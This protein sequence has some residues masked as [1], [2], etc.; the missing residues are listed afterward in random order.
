MRGTGLA[1]A[2]LLSV[3]VA[4]CVAVPPPVPMYAVP[5]QA[6]MAA[7]AAAGAPSPLIASP[8]PGKTE[9]V[10]EADDR[11]CR[12]DV[13]RLPKRAAAAQPTEAQLQAAQAEQA[14]PN[15]LPPPPQALPPGAA[16]LRCMTARGNQVQPLQPEVQ[17]LP[18]Y[19]YL[20]AYPVYAGVDYGYP[21]F[22]DDVFLL[23][24]YGGFGYRG[25][26]F[27][28]FGYGGYGYRG[29][30][31]YGY[32]GR[33]GGGYGRGYGGGY[34]GGGFGHGSFGHGG[35]GRGGFGHR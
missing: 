27:G 7:G 1:G 10:F 12:A 13:R 22:Y 26:G 14:D 31:G 3:G 6:P 29:Y 32:G 9:A 21:F 35:F 4:G 30:P 17:A 8:G 18:A 24:Y 11:A 34:G 33:F 5:P 15:V 20:P 19:G 2:M 23:R 28:R 16:F 25:Y